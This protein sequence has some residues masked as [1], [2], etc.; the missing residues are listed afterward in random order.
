MYGTCVLLQY[1][2]WKH[3]IAA[4]IALP[5]SV[6]CHSLPQDKEQGLGFSVLEEEV[7]KKMVV[8]VKDIVLGGPAY[9]DGR[10]Q[11]GDILLSVD[12]ESV[13]GKPYN[14]VSV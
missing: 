2:M 1:R 12:G 7:N 13:V 6:L 10:L 8:M 11:V 9:R 14:V 3:L 4:S 5:L